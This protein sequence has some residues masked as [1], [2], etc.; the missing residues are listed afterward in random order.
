MRPFLPSFSSQSLLSPSSSPLPWG[1]GAGWKKGSEQ[2]LPQPRPSW[3]FQAI[4]PEVRECQVPVLL[5][6][7]LVDCALGKK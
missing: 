1:G 4:S 6:Q 7:V 3:E 5:G 2:P